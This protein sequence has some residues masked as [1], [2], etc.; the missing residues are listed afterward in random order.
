MVCQ[1]SFRSNT[2][3]IFRA[4]VRSKHKHTL[5]DDVAVKSLANTPRF[6][7][8]AATIMHRSKCRRNQRKANKPK[9]QIC[10][11]R[12]KESEKKLVYNNHF[13]FYYLFY[14]RLVSCHDAIIEKKKRIKSL[15]SG[16]L[17]RVLLRCFYRKSFVC[18]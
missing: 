15:G 17:V 3:F 8:C 4:V 10:F 14:I 12:L 11:K 2:I 6:F 1:L 13:F 7:L 18:A 16:R 9:I 5:T